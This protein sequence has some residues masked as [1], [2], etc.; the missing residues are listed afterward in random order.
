MTSLFLMRSVIASLFVCGVITA[1]I[2]AQ[3]A[4]QSVAAPAATLAATPAQTSKFAADLAIPIS[5]KLIKAKLA[6]G[7][8]YYIQKNTKP[9]QKVELRLVIK[10]GSVL[11]DDD[12]QG[13]AHFVEHMAFNGSAHFKKNELVSFL[14]SIGVKFGADLNAYT[15]FDE[16]VYILPIPTDKP[17]NVEKGMLVLSDWAQGLSFD[18]AEIDKERGVILEEARLGKGAADRIRKQILPSVLHGSRYADR[19]PIGKEEVLK[20]FKHDAVKRFY[21]D[22]YRPDLMAVVVVGDID[23]QQAKLLIEKNFS[24]L[25]NPDKKRARVDATIPLKNTGEALIALDKEANIASI[26]ISQARYL[27]KNDGKFGS[28]RQR[29]IQSFFNVMLSNRLRELAQLPQP[30]FLG[31]GSGVSTLIGDYQELN[32]TAAIG[33]AGVQAAVDALIQENKRVAQFG[34]SAPELERAKSNSL[35]AMEHSYNE[36]DKTQ[37]AEF[38]AEFIRNFLSAESLPG[39]EAEYEF[40]KKIVQGISLE[41]INHYAKSVLVNNSP[42]LIIYQGNEKADHPIPTQD[43]LA[44][45]VNNAGK[46]EV[47]A[48][49]EKAVAKS[50]FDATPT[51][52]K[53]LSETKNAQL[54]TTE[55]TLSNG[56][57]VVMKP[58]DFKSDQ[59]LFLG[60]R[61]GGSATL[62]DADFL[63]ARFATT[64]VGAMGVK[65]LAPIELSKYLAGKS[66]SVS[67][68]F[69]ENS[70]GVSGSS[71]KDDLETALQVLHL[72]MLQ[73]RRDEALFT[74]FVSKQSDALR[75][76]MA[77][78]MAVFQE[79]MLAAT[80]PSHPRAP[81]VLKPEHIAQLDLD[82]MVAIYRGRFSSA[83]GMKFFMVGNFDIEKVKPLLQSYLGS[84]PTPEINIKS[85]DH[86]LRPYP[87]IIKKEVYAGKEQQSMITLQMHGEHTMSSADRLRFN[88]MVE[89]LQLRLTAKLREEMGAVY[90]P[91]VNGAIKRLPYQSHSVI[92]ALPSGPE[93]INALLKASFELIEQLKTTPVSDEEL[94]KVKEN[95]LKNRRESIKTNQFWLNGLSNAHLHQDDPA[96]IFLFEDKVKNLKGNEIQEAAK[97][98]LNMDNYIQVILYPESAKAGTS[99]EATSSK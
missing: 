48:Y 60:T 57:K 97:T 80:F 23:P 77:T 34:F 5:P 6:N 63:Q 75:N 53:I 69:S 8:T 31:A 17:E 44:K 55:L 19:L 89:V 45:L 88:A 58:T 11:E 13:L 56:I 72:A 54:G 67:T 42:K 29:R 59:I 92:L 10:A 35:L 25:R 76:Q 52:A 9:E 24:T 78:P 96:D 46:K 81:F 36:R 26:G 49:T 70:E 47:T 21:R 30:P 86:G 71:N 61:H 99:L 65:D 32:S 16:T 62:S 79:Q 98:Y 95:W 64:V 90:S 2:G 3:A 91:R 39:I 7:L 22:W 18:H 4:Q 50:L 74:S 84:L 85:I 43:E 83:Y 82:R 94:N 1:S 93:K 15:S 20:T 68:T 38:A 14:E 12:Q 73:P 33:K 37:S 40:H 27:N 28:Y 87:G 66:A 51:A 41:E